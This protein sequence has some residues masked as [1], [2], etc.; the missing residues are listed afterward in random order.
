VLP[1]EIREN[2]KWKLICLIGFGMEF[3]DLEEQHTAKRKSFA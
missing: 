2:R 3:G 1:E